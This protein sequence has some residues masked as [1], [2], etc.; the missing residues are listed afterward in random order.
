[1]VPSSCS[2]SP[3]SHSAHR[4]W[5][6]F[7]PRSTPSPHPSIDVFV[8]IPA[9]NSP[10]RYLEE[11]VEG[12]RLDETA[13]FLRCLSRLSTKANTGLHEAGDGR[14]DWV[15]GYHGVLEA[16]QDLVCKRTGGATLALVL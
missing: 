7:H 5:G 13:T 14:G 11:L 6:N 10:R 15:K 3:P 2:F 12:G 8:K 1:M 16:V 9:T 4:L